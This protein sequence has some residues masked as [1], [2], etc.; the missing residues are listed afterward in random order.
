ML[1]NSIHVNFENTRS[2]CDID[3]NCDEEKLIVL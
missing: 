1:F 3:G 2:G